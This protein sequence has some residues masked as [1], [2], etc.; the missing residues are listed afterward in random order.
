MK[1]VFLSV[2]AIIY[3]LNASA[4]FVAR[5]DIKEDIPGICDKKE[6]YAI[7]PSFKGQEEAVCPL[8]KVA[9][10]EKL[11]SEVV[12]L[13]DKPKY[14]DKGMVGLV[15]NCKGELVKC[16]IDNKTQSPE[17]DQ[18][19]VAVFNTLKVWKAGKL[20]GKEVDTSNLYSFNIK[21]GKIVFD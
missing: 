1:K 20:N 16:E 14:K 19:I 12:F 6:V 3:S 21:K 8:T 5:V 4:Q 9:I 15:V 2:I 13:K 10:L 17:L 7:I 18:Q 11:N